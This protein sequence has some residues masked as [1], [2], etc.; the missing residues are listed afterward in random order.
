MMLCGTLLPSY[1][2]HFTPY[3]ETL[4]QNPDYMCITIQAH[5][6]WQSLFKDPEARDIVRRVNRMNIPLRP[7]MRLA[8]PKNL[9][10]ITIYDVSPFPRYIAAPHEKTLYVN[11][12]ELAFGAYDEAGELLWWGPISPGIGACHAPGGCASPTGIYRIIRKQDVDCISTAFP[13]R[14]DGN[15]GGAQMP[16]CMHFFQGYA[17]HGSNDVPGYSAS[18]GCIRLFIE[19]ARWLNEEFIEV[20][21]GGGFQGT[22]VVI[23]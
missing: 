13:R 20:P 4:C 17:L 21:G 3:G 7:G 2:A 6:S 8:I 23:S 10:R 22:K 16:F 9:D 19:D 12:Q 14:S 11:Q 1:A 15:N 18:H 5:E